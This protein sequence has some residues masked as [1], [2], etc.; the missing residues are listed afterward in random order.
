MIDSLNELKK[1]V[2]VGFVRGSDFPKAFEQF[3]DSE[4]EFKQRKLIF[5]YRGLLI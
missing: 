2:S 1:I 4:I 5:K 3:G